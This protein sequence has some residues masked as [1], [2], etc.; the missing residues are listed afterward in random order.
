M[1]DVVEAYPLAWPQGYP[2]TERTRSSQFQVSMAVARDHLLD[3][4]TRLKA[5][6]VVISTNIETYERGGRRIP[7]ANRT[8][9][10]T[11]VAVYFEWQGEQHVLACDKWKTVAEN[12]R[13][14]GLSVAAM[15]GLDR[16]GA[17]EILKRAFTG[18]KAL[19]QTGSGWA[20]WEVLGVAK[21]APRELVERAYRIAAQKA[22]P[23]KPTGSRA[24]WDRLQEAYRQAKSA[25]T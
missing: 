15:R 8:V 7:Y 16:W 5:R 4:L 19:P 6:G 23:D 14:L 12:V 24:D 21:D 2:R 20:W 22:H 13:A 10:D 9:E 17:T 25:T 11:G 3:E 18:F 1:A